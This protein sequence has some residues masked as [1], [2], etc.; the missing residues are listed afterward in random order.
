[1][2]ISMCFAEHGQLQ[3]ETPRDTEQAE[4]WRGNTCLE[5]QGNPLS[6]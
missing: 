3:A 6:P 5:Q 2:S 1:M 4:H